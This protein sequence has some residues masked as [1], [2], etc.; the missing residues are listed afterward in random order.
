MRRVMVDF[1]YQYLFIAIVILYFGRFMQLIFFD[2]SKKP[3]AIFIH[4]GSITAKY[5][6]LHLNL[7]RNSWLKLFSAEFK[8]RLLGH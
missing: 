1:Y 7:Q 6:R 5:H 4:F 8:Y 3:F 2:H